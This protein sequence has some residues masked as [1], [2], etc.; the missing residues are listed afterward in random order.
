MENTANMASKWTNKRF[1]TVTIL[2]R[3]DRNYSHADNW[4]R[5]LSGRRNHWIWV[6]YIYRTSLIMTT[7]FLEKLLL[8]IQHLIN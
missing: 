5:I 2:P 8:Q 6:S 7:G 3:N 4:N 1:S